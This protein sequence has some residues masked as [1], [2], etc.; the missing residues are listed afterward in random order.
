MVHILD[1]NSGGKLQTWTRRSRPV[2]IDVFF[3]HP[4][5]KFLLLIIHYFKNYRPR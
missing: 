1:V 4:R 2:Q 5:I 3:G